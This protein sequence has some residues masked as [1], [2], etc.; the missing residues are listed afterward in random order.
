MVKFNGGWCT[1]KNPRGASF[2]YSHARRNGRMIHGP[3]LGG[4]SPGG[5]EATTW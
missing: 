4:I 1:S 3:G 5:C 2:K